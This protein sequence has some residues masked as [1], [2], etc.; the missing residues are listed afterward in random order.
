MHEDVS[1]MKLAS[2]AC[3]QDM[4]STHTSASAAAEV[5]SI[6]STAAIVV[7][8]LALNLPKLWTTKTRKSQTAIL[9]NL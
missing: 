6:A 9:P 7:P 8:A 1:D 3:V 4:Q 5:A 2:P